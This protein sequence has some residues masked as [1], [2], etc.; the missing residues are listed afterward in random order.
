MS[1]QRCLSACCSPRKMLLRVSLGQPTIGGG[2]HVDEVAGPAIVP[3]GI[4]VLVEGAARRVIAD[5]PV[6]IEVFTATAGMNGDRI[7]PGG[8]SCGSVKI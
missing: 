2:T 1:E 6:F 7:V 5:E 3:L 4:A 8:A